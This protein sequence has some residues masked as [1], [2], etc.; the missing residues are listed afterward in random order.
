[1]AKL[2]WDDDIVYYIIEKVQKTPFIWD[3]NHSLFTNKAKKNYFWQRT[4]EKINRKYNPT[5]PYK[6]VEVL[7]KWNNLK[8][9]Y[10]HEN[11][12]VQKAITSGSSPEEVEKVRSSWKFRSHLTFLPESE[13]EK[14]PTNRVKKVKR[15]V[16][17]STCSL[18]PHV[19]EC[20]P[21]IKATLIKHE[22]LSPMRN[23]GHA[24]SDY[25]SSN[26]PD[27]SVNMTSNSLFDQSMTFSHTQSNMTQMSDIQGAA[28]FGACVS[29]EISKL[30]EDLQITAKQKIFY[31]LMELQSQQCSRRSSGK[32]DNGGK[33]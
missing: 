22:M 25:T 23:N 4:T 20:T 32:I 28:A 8:S 26:L 27:D 9:Y 18:D 24:S 13:L 16:L 17:S 14:K 5:P 3:Q 12:K 15:D 7:R 29:A 1:M 21:D 6:Q 2:A 10:T 30:S 11:Q 19:V 33:F 31:I